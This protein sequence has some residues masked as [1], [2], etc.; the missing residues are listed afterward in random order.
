VCSSCFKNFRSRQRLHFHQKTHQANNNMNALTVTINDNTS[1]RGTA[2][3]ASSST[4][5][6]TNSPMISSVSPSSPLLLY[7]FHQRAEVEVSGEDSSEQEVSA[8]VLLQSLLFPD[9]AD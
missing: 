5:S 1:S 7:N 6:D 4:F 3:S 9:L 8:E 2:E